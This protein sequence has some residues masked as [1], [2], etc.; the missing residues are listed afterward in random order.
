MVVCGIKLELAPPKPEDPAKGSVPR[1]SWEKNIS[2]IFA[3]RISCSQR[4]VA[5][6]LPQP[7]PPR[8]ALGAGADGFQLLEAGNRQLA[9]GQLGRPVRQ[10]GETRVVSKKPHC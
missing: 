9:A 8:P 6:H 10:T 7:V 2:F 3:R 5:A 4:G 1:F